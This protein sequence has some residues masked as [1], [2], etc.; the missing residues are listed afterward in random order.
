MLMKSCV[1]FN[2]KTFFFDKI[3]GSMRKV[4]VSEFC[5]RKLMRQRDASERREK[6]HQD[7]HHSFQ[8]N[9]RQFIQQRKSV[10]SIL[11]ETR[12]L[13]IGPL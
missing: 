10:C 4:T 12:Q 6:K 13:M 7:S 3:Q 9:H 8:F 2:E 1:V 5:M 11:I